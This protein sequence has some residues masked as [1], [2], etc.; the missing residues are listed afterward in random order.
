MKTL[1]LHIGT[2][3]TATSS[4][5]RFLDMNQKTLRAHNYSYQIFPFEY[6][7]VSKHRNGY[8]LSGP[9]LNKSLTEE[10]TR[11]YRERL[12][13]GLDLVRKQFSSC[14]NVI[15]T[16]EHLWM[17][18]NYSQWDPLQ[19]LMDHAGKNGYQIKVIVY[20]RRQDEFE[21]SRWNQFVKGRFYSDSL[22][23]HIQKDLRDN[24]LILYYGQALDK[25][26][27]R[28]GKGNL[29]VRRYDRSSWPEG[30]IY[31]DFQKALNLPDDIP[32][33]YPKGEANLGLKN[34][35][36]EFKRILNGIDFLKNE[37]KE[38]LGKY[39]RQA[40]DGQEKREDYGFMTADETRQFLSLFEKENAYVAETYIGDGNPLFSGEIREVKKW[41]PDNPY[42]EEDFSV[43]LST[44]SDA[45][46]KEKEE[47]KK[48]KEYE[49][50][51]TS[52]RFCFKQTLACLRRK[53]FKTE[54]T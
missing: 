10:D 16:D 6:P 28:I 37:Q 45:L 50:K 34:N 3:K 7:N 8:F 49:K 38:F 20:L 22:N 54:S 47:A 13:T 25:I 19:I 42:M 41:T 12:N 18:L 52:V 43:L 51:L 32:L 1:Y 36:L 48:V 33:E 24:P 14:D 30:S 26:A 9:G 21:L 2:P 40:S 46:M 35:F 17:A 11:Q 4:L 39:I 53:F 29:L 5:Q 31:L 27:E 23:S 15:L 44:I